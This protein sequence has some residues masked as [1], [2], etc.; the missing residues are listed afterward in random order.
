MR[1]MVVFSDC[2]KQ[3]P[4]PPQPSPHPP[5][6]APQTVSPTF[7]LPS[8]RSIASPPLIVFEP[9]FPNALAPDPGTAQLDS[10]SGSGLSGGAKAG[11]AFGALFGES[12]WQ[13]GIIC[14]SH[15][16]SID[17]GLLGRLLHCA[18]I[19]AAIVLLVLLSRCLKVW[20]AVHANRAAAN[21]F[22]GDASPRSRRQFL[23]ASGQHISS[24]SYQSTPAVGHT[25]VCRTHAAMLAVLC[26]SFRGGYCHAEAACTHSKI[27]RAWALSM[28]MT[29]QCMACDMHCPMLS[30]QAT[31]TSANSK[32]GG[33][34]RGAPKEMLIARSVD[35]TAQ[36]VRRQQSQSLEA[37]LPF[38]KLMPYAVLQHDMVLSCRAPR[39]FHPSTG[40]R[41]KAA[42]ASAAVGPRAAGALTA[43]I[44][45]PAI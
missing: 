44:I 17:R 43:A 45:G 34:Q 11:I 39:S 25:D 12:A 1:F 27:M 40:C 28:Q 37:I 18:G 5:P 4:P 10:G 15:P 3:R 32:K 14:V 29:G 13:C 9:T 7:K 22:D 38:P 21:L 8:S 33:S 2:R 26:Q 16:P 36:A 31:F 35:V 30:L 42:V 6:A 19:I 23:P 24:T 20:Q 41:G